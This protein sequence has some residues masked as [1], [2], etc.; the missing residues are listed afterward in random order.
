MDRYL[1]PHFILGNVFH[2]HKECLEKVIL[3]VQ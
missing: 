2:S 3:S 1:K